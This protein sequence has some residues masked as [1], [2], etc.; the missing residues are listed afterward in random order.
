MTWITWNGGKCPVEPETV[1]EVEVRG[2]TQLEPIRA[3]DLRWDW[4]NGGFPAEIVA[5]RVVDGKGP[6]VSAK[7]VRFTQ[8][9]EKPF[10]TRITEA[11]EKALEAVSE[12]VRVVNQLMDGGRPTR[13]TLLDQAS[14]NIEAA[15]ALARDYARKEG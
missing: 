15:A 8:P 1:V 12:M 5:Y 10:S 9:P 3:G 13:L 4:P 14:C 2:G 7:D 11:E 6:W